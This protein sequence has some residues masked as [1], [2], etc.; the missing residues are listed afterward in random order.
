L[1]SKITGLGVCFPE[2]CLTN[3]DLEK[4]VDTSN[5]W[6]IQ[7]T[8]IEKRYICDENTFTSDL[9]SVAAKNAIA[10]AG[11]DPLDIDMI[12]IPTATP[13]MMTPST[14]CLVQKNIGAHNAAAVDINA[15]CTGFI[16]ALTMADCYIKCGMFK[17]ILIVGAETL[18]KIT[19][20]SD[21]ATCVLFGDGAGAAVV[22][23]TDGNDCGILQTCLKAD[24]RIGH[25]LTIGNHRADEH[26]AKKQKLWMDGSEVFKF[27]V[28]VMTEAT[29]EV[30][31][32]QGF[33]T[34]DITMIIPHQANIR[35]IEGAMKRLKV[36]DDKVI[37]NI[38]KYGNTSSA[39]IPAALFEA[40]SEGRVKRGDNIVLVGFGGGLTYGAVLM[41]Y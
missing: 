36:S 17:N 3:P 30:L 4:M 38:Q 28:R 12:I 16:Y 37:I 41:R 18:S 23:A 26:T 15:A 8:G 40:V 1:N 39:S 9:A 31:D 35:I 32:K 25:N 10:D 2:K 20:W 24:G 34:D 21:R 5:E 11:L 33:T 14:A 13:D 6:I 22:S 29:R 19:D 27:A 7:R